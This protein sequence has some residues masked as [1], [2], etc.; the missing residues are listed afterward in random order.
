MTSLSVPSCII[1]GLGQIGMGYDLSL[2]HDKFIYTH[3]RAFASHSGFNLVCGVDPSEERRELFSKYYNRPAYPT[4]EMALK[5]NSVDL[6][7]IAVPTSEHKVTLEKVLDRSKPHTILCEKP[8]GGSVNE[9]RVM[10]QRCLDHNINLYVNYVRQSCPGA[11]NVKRMFDTGEIE[12][13][14]RGVIWYSKGFIHNGSHF[15]DIAKYWLGDYESAQI[16]N[17]GRDLEGVGAEPEVKVTFANGEVTFMPACEEHYSHYTVELISPSGRL[18]WAGN[19]LF[20]QK[21]ERDPLIKGYKILS[22]MPTEIA[23]GM[24]CYQRNVVEQLSLALAGKSASICSGKEA[25]NTIL[26][27]H[28]ILE[29]RN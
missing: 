13:P 25:L 15:F 1:I 20:W 8:L 3:A 16:I 4:I 19:G 11:I 12:T 23:V 7:V 21:A 24:D 27:M 26:S 14:V 6:V 9:A 29:I 2:D 18:Y 10:V 5:N 17:N 22:S 28:D